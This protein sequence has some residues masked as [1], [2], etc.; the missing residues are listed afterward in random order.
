MRK[1]EHCYVG[2]LALLYLL[3]FFLYDKKV[4]YLYESECLH[5]LGNNGR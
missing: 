5:F 4:Q 1:V 3:G 2:I